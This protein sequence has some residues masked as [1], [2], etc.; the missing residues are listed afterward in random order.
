MC[1]RPLGPEDYLQLAEAFH[2]I[3]LS[4]VPVLIRERRAE[5]RRF[6]TLIDTLYDAHVGLIVSADAE[7]EALHPAGDEAFLF[8]RTASRLIEM[9]SADY[10]VE[11]RDRSQTVPQRDAQ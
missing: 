4:G 7:P 11:R 6:I 8:E 9:R 10:L 1:A 2:T 3:I 5:A